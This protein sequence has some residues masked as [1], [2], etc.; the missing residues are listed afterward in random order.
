MSS[1]GQHVTPNPSGGWRVFRSGSTR[2][3]RLFPDRDAAVT[4]ARDRARRERS[5]LYL[6]G[7]DG[8][9]QEKTSYGTDGHRP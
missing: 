5:A 6:H 7:R 9:V 3:S 1:N 4:Y 8:M 2:A